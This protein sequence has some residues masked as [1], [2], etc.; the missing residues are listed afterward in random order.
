MSERILIFMK[1]MEYMLEGL[2]KSISYDELG[3]LYVETSN[4]NGTK[5]NVC[6]VWESGGIVEMI[7][8]LSAR[9]NVINI[10]SMR[11]SCQMI[12]L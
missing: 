8:F 12:G 9:K 4:L 3:N 11:L 1:A 6:Q 2:D 7:I 10:M 5:K